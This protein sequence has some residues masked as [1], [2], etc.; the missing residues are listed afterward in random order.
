MPIRDKLRIPHS[1]QDLPLGNDPTEKLF[2]CFISST[3]P[4]TNL[5]WCPDV[6]AALPR[7]NKAF[8]SEHAPRLALVH[9]GQKPE[10]VLFLFDC[11]IR[12]RTRAILTSCRWKDMNNKYRKD[13]GINALPTLVRYQCIDGA[14]SAT[15][16]LVE[17]E[18]MDE[19]KLSKLV[20]E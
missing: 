6:R 18:I 5:P 19:K 17:G 15:G 20:S 7:L 3:D 14:V 9:V 13:W 16:R 8:S 11:G 1:A 12:P 2:V 10:Y 4:S